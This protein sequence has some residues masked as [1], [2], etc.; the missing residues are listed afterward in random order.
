M[1]PPRPECGEPTGFSHTHPFLQILF[2]FACI[3]LDPYDGQWKAAD[4][5]V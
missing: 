2:F 1:E 5:D 4:D 3:D